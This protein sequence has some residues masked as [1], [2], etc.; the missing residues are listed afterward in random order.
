MET[1]A[2]AAAALGAFKATAAN[3]RAHKQAP[4][5]RP[6]LAV[7]TIRLSLS[8]SLSRTLTDIRCCLPCRRRGE[9][10]R[11]IPRDY[12]SLRASSQITRPPSS[13]S[14]RIFLRSGRRGPN[15]SDINL[16]HTLWEKEGRE[17]ERGEE[18]AYLC[19]YWRN[20]AHGSS[21]RGFGSLRATRRVCVRVSFHSFSPS[22]AYT[23]PRAHAIVYC[24]SYFGILLFNYD[25]INSRHIVS[26]L[27]STR[28]SV[29]QSVFV[30]LYSC[31]PSFFIHVL[32]SRACFLHF[33]GSRVQ[34][35]LLFIENALYEAREKCPRGFSR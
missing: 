20:L 24:L 12:A 3:P 28:V 25:A 26:T 4:R 30:H 35:H 31:S 11:E 32:R 27:P 23:Q 6:S 9:R 2:L 22:L 18:M 8:L 16:Y 13:L 19:A 10:G 29:L 1:T 17:R 33:F 21:A 7:I 14:L 15:G 5:G 34:Q